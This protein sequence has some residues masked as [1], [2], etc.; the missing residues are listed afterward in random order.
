MEAQMVMMFFEQE[1]FAEAEKLARA[2]TASYPQHSLGWKFLGTALMQL[3]RLEEA[4]EPMTRSARINPE[5]AE[6][7]NNLGSAH[8]RLGH[9]D[10][11]ELF[12]KRAL[13]V[14]PDMQVAWTNLTGLLLAQKKYA[15]AVQYYKLKLDQ[16]PT[17]E[18]TQH[19]VAMYS[20]EQ[21]A[22]APAGY[23]KK[24]FDFYADKFD[25]H[26]QGELGYKVPAQLVDLVST[27]L[28]AIDPTW[29]L[30]DLGC[31]TG[32]VGASV[33]KQAREL[34]GVDLSS[35]MLEM[36]QARQI[37]QRLE[38]QDVLTMMQAEPDASY[39]VIVSADVFIYVGRIDDVVEQAHRLLRP[40]GVFAFS[41]EQ[42]QG[43]TTDEQGHAKGYRLQPT[44]RYTH[45]LD[46]LHTLAQRHAFS[47]LE[48]VDTPIR[49]EARLPVPGC[50]AV[51]RR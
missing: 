6:T 28:P 31:G 19:L 47:W 18:H 43:E 32:L 23:V 16:D 3:E 22:S 45:G 51:W 21:T 12:Y 10:D 8:E 34:V 24:V 46:Y 14:Q 27:H 29:K 40:G 41:I 39:D 33:G 44:G 7:F 17:D 26:L 49:L 13:N 42:H 36:A 4:L 38:C 11:A 30:L 35:K 37:Y 9:F 48:Q 15:E 50:L 5:D 2:M 25:A 1:R 20:G